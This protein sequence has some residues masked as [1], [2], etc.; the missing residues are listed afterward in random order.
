MRVI[1]WRIGVRAERRSGSPG[2]EAV[3]LPVFREEAVDLGVLHGR[4][5]GKDVGEVFLGVDLS[6][7]AALDNGVNH[8]TA[9]PS[10]GVPDE[11]PSLLADAAWANRIFDQI[12]PTAELCRVADS[13][14]AFS[15]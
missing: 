3:F 9:P 12:M 13:I 2:V 1:G 5:P 14:S 8:R 15:A 7:A 10:L 11:E 6:P 4:H